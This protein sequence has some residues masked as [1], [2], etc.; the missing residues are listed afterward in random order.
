MSFI[1]LGTEARPQVV[2]TEAIKVLEVVKRNNKGSQL[3][4]RNERGTELGI[5]TPPP[6]S[7][8]GAKHTD[9]QKTELSQQKLRE[10]TAIVLS[11]K[12]KAKQEVHNFT[13]FVLEPEPSTEAVAEETSEAT[14]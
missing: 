7:A 9:E 4:V 10:I 13:S 5:W 12:P 8:S 6:R 2:D 14:E 3:I 11:E 1:V